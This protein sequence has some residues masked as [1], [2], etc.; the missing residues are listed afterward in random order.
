MACGLLGFVCTIVRS[1]TVRYA[2]PPSHAGQD[3]KNLQA[4]FGVSPPAGN[5]TANLVK[6]GPFNACS[7][8]KNSCADLEGSILLRE[9][10]YSDTTM[11]MAA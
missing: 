4:V 3:V 11:A 6:A 2:E 1:L 10:G 7:E 8:L 9:G 5:I